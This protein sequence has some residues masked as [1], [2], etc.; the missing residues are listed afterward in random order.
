MD[1]HE[2][3]ELEEDH[4]MIEKNLLPLEFQEMNI[5]LF[6]YVSYSAS[7]T[8]QL[9]CILKPLPTVSLFCSVNLL[10]HVA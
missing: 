1:Q 9:A 7:L 10:G 4:R 8:P 2:E 3:A 6:D 5:S